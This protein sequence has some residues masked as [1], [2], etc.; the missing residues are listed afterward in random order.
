MKKAAQ[1]G[2]LVPEQ[3]QQRNHA[4]AGEMAKV[5]AAAQPKK[6]KLEQN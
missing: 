3:D 5:A 1:Q 2:V 4:W 6:L